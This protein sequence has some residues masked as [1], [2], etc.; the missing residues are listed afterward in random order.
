M[1]R[2]V[3]TLRFD[4]ECNLTGKVRF[5]CAIYDLV[6]R[7]SSCMARYGNVRDFR[8]E[9]LDRAKKTPLSSNFIVGSR[10][11]KF[12]LFHKLTQ[13]RSMIGDNPLRILLI[14]SGG[15]EHALAWKLAK[16]GRVEV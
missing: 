15:R 9:I 2:R 3:Q 1:L 5:Q 6:K 16:S 10:I 7:R 14:G 8:T 11:R 4:L 12:R 13:R